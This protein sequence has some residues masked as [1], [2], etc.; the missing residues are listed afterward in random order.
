MTGKIQI[1]LS[2]IESPAKFAAALKAHRSALAKHRKGKPNQAAPRAAVA[3]DLIDALILRVP[4]SGPVEHRGPDRFEI[5]PYE[6]VDDTPTLAERK[7]A[8]L[9]ELHAAGQAAI[10]KIM[11]PARA[12]LLSVEYADAGVKSKDKRT[13]ADKKAI[14]R[15]EKFSGR[16]NDINRIVARA[17]VAIE[18]LT[19]KTIGKWTAPTFD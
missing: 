8:L 14:E 17:A 3:H 4:D 19:E 11:S 16:A 10:D 5:A 12:R 1:P 6:I 15:F 9:I 18:D 2:R 13:A 7:Q